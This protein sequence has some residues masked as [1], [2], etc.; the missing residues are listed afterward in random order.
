MN[1]GMS[2]R[3]PPALKGQMELPFLSILRTISVP[4]SILYGFM[5]IQLLPCFQL[6]SIILVETLLC[7]SYISHMV[8]PHCRLYGFLQIFVQSL[9]H[10][11]ASSS[12]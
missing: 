6:I 10:F 11:K 9:Q 2:D 1:L 3:Q 5:G 8:L 7:T 12:S 4:I